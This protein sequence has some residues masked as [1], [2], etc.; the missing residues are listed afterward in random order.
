MHLK[1]VPNTSLNVL[2]KS[3]IRPKSI[4]NASPMRPQSVSNASPMRPQSVPKVSPIRPQCFPNTCP[5]LNILIK[6]GIQS[7]SVEGLKCDKK[8]QQQKSGMKERRDAESC[9]TKNKNCKVVYY[10]KMNFIS[11]YSHSVVPGGL[12]VKS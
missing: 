2:N 9:G 1:C 12:E 5:M 8:Q 11:I 4:P 7:W 3:P 10:L 6:P